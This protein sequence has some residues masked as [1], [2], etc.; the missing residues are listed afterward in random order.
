MLPHAFLDAGSKL[1]CPAWSP[2]TYPPGATRAN[3]NVIDLSLVTLDFDGEHPDDIELVTDAAKKL[4]WAMLVHSTW[5]NASKPVSMR[6][7][8]PLSRAVTADEWLEVWQAVKAALGDFSDRVCKDPSRLYFGAYAPVGDEAHAFGHVFPGEPIDPDALL[9]NPP[10][11]TSNRDEASR[12][13]RP[14]PPTTSGETVTR[15]QLDRFSKTLLRKHSEQLQERGAQLKRIVLGEAFAEPGNI[16]NTI[17]RIAN[18]L[19]ERF[20]AYSADSIARHFKQSLDLMAEQHPDY[21]MSVVQV[22]YKIQRAQQ[23]IAVALKEQEQEH[24]ENQQQQIKD[25]FGN[26]RTEPYTKE[27]LENYPPQRWLIQ[28]G[29]SYYARVAEQFRGPYMKDEA[30]SAPMRDLAPAITAGLELYTM[31]TLGERSPKT[32]GRRVNP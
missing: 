25:A 28:K 15:D 29:S 2:S 8:M 17:F 1:D 9:G 4:G 26:G 5:S 7:I 10:P 16:D 32:L 3:K 14:T 19:A 13:D 11:V 31:N 30:Q 21:E 6:A 18:L 27:E 20:P 12:A 23:S 22:A 24:N